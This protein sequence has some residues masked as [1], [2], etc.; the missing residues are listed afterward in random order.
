MDRNPG[1]SP[2]KQEPTMRQD[3]RVRFVDVLSVREY[4]ALWL[5]ET[6]S[7]FGDQLARVALT[8]LVF[9]RT[10]SA[11]LTALTYA[12]TF[13]PALLGGALLSG[14]ADR[15]ARR[16]VMIWC[17]L[18]RAVL[19]ALM[20]L[21][22]MP[23]PL[24]AAL[25]VLAVLA[26]SPFTAAQTALLPDVLDDEKY[27]VATALRT[28][29]NQLA[30]LAGFAGGGLVIAAIGP[31]VG[32]AVDAAT[33]VVSAGILRLGV[34]PHRLAAT[35]PAGSQTY[36]AQLRSGVRL[37]AADPRLRTWLGLAWLYGLYVVP[38]GLV[39]PFAA[40]A[41][42]GTVAIGLLLAAGP[43]GS[44][45]G[46]YLFVRL[47]PAH[48]RPKVVGPLAVAAGLPLVAFAA[49]PGVPSGIV[50]LFLSGVGT[51]YLIQATSSF[52]QAVPTG[53]RGQAVGLASSG[54]LVAQG[55]GVLLAGVLAQ[56]LGVAQTIALS[57]AV[58]AA[59]A[60]LLTARLRAAGRRAAPADG[61]PDLA[62][63]Q[64]A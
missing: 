8:V 7:G 13:L 20:A 28:L 26:G 3:R 39:A 56:H 16:S 1:E 61:H 35:A 53:Q 25:L 10:K 11:S 14:L 12:L 36:R 55:A 23:V 5:A 4:R 49:Y 24:I 52:N 54:F 34:R 48:A 60:I 17:D 30:Q 37:I 42:G 64:D 46:A 63:R 27:V 41:G 38:E 40:Q 58:G 21:P 50:L 47:I 19:I 22:G 2:Q 32:L 57:G 6:Q 33:F 43:A 51:A 44:G 31:H 18:L 59:L 62:S 15:K 29:S 9:D 45:L